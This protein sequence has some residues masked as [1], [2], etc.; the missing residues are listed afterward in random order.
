MVRG[1]F[2]WNTDIMRKLIWIKFCHEHAD[3]YEYLISDSY[4]FTFSC[5]ESVNYIII[6]GSSKMV[7]FF[8]VITLHVMQLSQ[9]PLIVLGVLCS[10]GISKHC[11]KD[12]CIC[13]IYCKMYYVQNYMHT[14][15]ENKWHEVICTV[16][17]AALTATFFSGIR[18]FCMSFTPSIV[19]QTL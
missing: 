10:F 15:N 5:A 17:I 9:H 19:T 7:N 4:Y 8:S 11:I 18:I 3:F 2:C 1:V 13:Q 14:E 6:S 16:T 12:L